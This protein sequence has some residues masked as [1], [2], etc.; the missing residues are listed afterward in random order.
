MCY[1]I[2]R[3]KSNLPGEPANLRRLDKD[4]WLLRWTLKQKLF[5]NISRLSR[6]CPPPPLNSGVPANLRRQDDDALLLRSTLK[7]EVVGNISLEKVQRVS[8]NVL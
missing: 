3:S 1:L 7:Q 5:G 8:I 2:A 4:A 6:I